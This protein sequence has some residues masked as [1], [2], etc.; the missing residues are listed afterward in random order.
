MGLIGPIRGRG[1][2]LHGPW[3]HEGPHPLIWCATPSLGISP[4]PEVE[5]GWNPSLAYIGRGR[6]AL[7]IIIFFRQVLFSLFLLSPSLRG[8]PLFGVY[9]WLGISPP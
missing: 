1:S 8:L 5:G 4:T 6:G 7:L 3:R 9:N 2:P